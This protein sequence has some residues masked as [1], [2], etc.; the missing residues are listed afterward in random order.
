MYAYVYMYHCVCVCVRVRYSLIA[1][2]VAGRGGSRISV[3][4]SSS[5]G[6]IHAE[7]E[8]NPGLVSVSM[9]V[10]IDL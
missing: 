4:G 7:T 10:S 8:I 9:F 5:R 3:L 6:R 2:A 1:T